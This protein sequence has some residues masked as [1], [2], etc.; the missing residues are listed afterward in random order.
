MGAYPPGVGVVLHVPVGELELRREVRLGQDLVL[1]HPDD[2]G[3]VFD[4]CRAVLLAVHAVRARP[5][6]VEIDHLAHQRLLGRGRLGNRRFAAIFLLSAPFRRDRRWRLHKPGS[7]EVLDHLLRGERLAREVGRTA[8]LAPPAARTGVGIEDL[9]FGKLL[10]LS[11]A[12]GLRRLEIPDR[13]E[14]ARGLE[15][16]HEVVGGSGDDMDQPRVGDVG[17]EGER[18]RGMHPPGYL[19]EELRL[20]RIEARKGLGER[21][22]AEGPDLPG[23]TG[24]LDPEGLDDEP[25]HDDPGEEQQHDGVIRGVVRLSLIAEAVWPEDVPPVGRQEDADQHGHAEQVHQEGEDE[26]DLPAQ[27]GPAER[28]G[29][30]ELRGIEGRPE[31]EDK[32]TEEDQTVHDGGIGVEE[33]FPLEEHVLQERP[34]PL[35]EAIHAPLRLAEGQPQ[36][37]PPV[38]AVGD[39]REGD[40]RE[41]KEER[42]KGL[43]IPENLSSFISHRKRDVF[44]NPSRREFPSRT[45]WRLFQENGYE[46]CRRSAGRPT[47]APRR[48]VPVTRAASCTLS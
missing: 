3:D 9:L 2:L 1:P 4:R 37:P 40:R 44:H 14:R 21:P 33:G 46:W 47:A 12:E 16:R 23:G 34:D 5:E 41:E 18:D 26:I 39:D 11:H 19:V 20:P 24:D 31:D 30:M 27:E 17:D 38:D 7:L 48:R 15:R 25:G 13:L 8:V 10:E 36:L 45:F 35:R 43:G 6:L 28:L 32:K 22:A 42:L 29:D